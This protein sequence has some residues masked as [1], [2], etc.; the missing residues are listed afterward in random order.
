MVGVEDA[1]TESPGRVGD[2][3]R[4]HGVGQVHGQEGHVDVLKGFHLRGVLG[5]SSNVDPLVAEGDDVSVADPLRMI[6]Q[7]LRPDV[8]D[9]VGSDGFNL[10]PFHRGRL[11]VGHDHGSFKAVG[12]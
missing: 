2:H 3:L 7:A 11:T 4:R 1:R 9:V 5:V 8:H 10:E 6:G 12:A